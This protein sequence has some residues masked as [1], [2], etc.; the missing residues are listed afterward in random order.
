MPDPL[1]TLCAFLADTAFADLP[2]PVVAHTRQVVADTV[3]AMAGGAAE[4][5]VAA[6]TAR[7]A[8]AE[9]PASVIGAGR[10]TDPATAAFLNGTG[11]TFLEMDEGNQF[12]R[13]HPAIHV[14]PSAFAYA[15]A[16]GAAGAE[17]VRAIV[18]GYEVGSRIGI[19]CKLRPT[20][21]PHGTW[22][23][24]GSAVAVGL[25]A[26]LDAGRL[27]TLI[28]IASSLGLATS[29]QTMLQG[30]TVRNTYAGLSGQMGL[31][32]L[33]LLE[34]G[35]TGEHDGLATV[36]GTVVSEAWAPDE[37]TAELGNRWEIARNYFKRHSCC[38]YNHA[39]LDA[40]DRILAAH[41]PLAPEEVAEVT[42]ETYSLA[43]EL[44]NR[45][46]QNTLAGK[47]SVP[48]AI[49]TTLVN[50]GSGVM[51]FTWDAVRDARIQALAV[52]VTVTEDPAL[53]AMMPARRPS[54]V[55]L[56]LT[57][58]EILEAETL[59][60]RGDAEDPYDADELEAKYHELCVRVWDREV[61]TALR[62]ALFGLDAAASMAEVTRLM[63]RTRR[64]QAAK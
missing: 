28:N 44:S 17:V 57:S 39:S 2:G 23:T 24:V 12:A 6:L 21:H 37:L 38:R 50:G 51:S 45:A 56:R 26:G 3:A 40:L 22:G 16:H 43:A 60:N 55:R 5:E 59:I 49:A 30:G 47:F 19:A 20:M 7:R 36:Y 48:F 9:G 27:R 10:R 61:A 14:V 34:S 63:A 4:P 18:L 41:G 42:V 35:F 62:A 31:L 52:K 13:G 29:R 25:L 53:T 64:L 1:D 46:P 58:G 33:D 11:G 8:T 15:E 54:R 32:A